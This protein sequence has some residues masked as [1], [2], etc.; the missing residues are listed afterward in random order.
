MVSKVVVPRINGAAGPV[1]FALQEQEVEYEWRSLDTNDAYGRMLADLWREGEGF[2]ML[3]HDIIP[4]PGAL[5]RLAM[6]SEPWCTHAYPGP[7]LFMS[8]G[9]TKITADAIRRAPHLYQAW[10][11]QFW[12]AVDAHMI[13]ALH[14]H[15]PLHGHFP[16][17][18]HTRFE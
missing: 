1:E 18:R 14:A 9:V 8:I 13:P 4:P 12:G 10:E 17:F 15:F 7:Q 2:I 6:C 3:E 5:I 16:P 11:G